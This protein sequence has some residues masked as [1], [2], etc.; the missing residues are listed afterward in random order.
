MLRG[1]RLSWLF[2]GAVGA[3]EPAP[4]HACAA[5]VEAAAR[6]ACYD[7]AFPVTPAVRQAAAARPLR[8]FGLRT[9]DRNGFVDATIDRVEATI[10]AIEHGSRRERVLVLD[11]GQAWRRSNDAD[12]GH[13][14]VGDRVEIR[15]GPLGNHILRTPARVPVPVARVR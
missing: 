12:R 5:V 13:V 9:T 8:E 10:T 6:L 2:A 14:A 15:R 7:T 1:L 4:G 3:S 11:N